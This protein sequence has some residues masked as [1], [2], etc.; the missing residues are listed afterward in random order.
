MS[1]LDSNPDDPD[2]LT[3]N[4]PSRPSELVSLGDEDMFRLL[5]KVAFANYSNPKEYIGFEVMA[6]LVAALKDS[7][8]A[9]D[10]A[11][12]RLFWTT[13]ALVILTVALVAMTGV[14]VWLTTRL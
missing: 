5:H 6:R 12:R 11:A 3:F 4:L 14:L 10:R 9:S 7:K 2:D 1:A 13:V 8:T